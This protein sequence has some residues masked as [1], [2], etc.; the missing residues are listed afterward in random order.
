MIVG[1][2]AGV[3][4]MFHVGHLNLLR[5]AAEQCDR[6]IVGVTTDE[7]CWER[8]GKKP[9]VPYS[10]RLDIVSAIRFVDAAVPQDVYDKFS[11]WETHRF[12]RIFVG[13][14]WQGTGL[15]AEYERRFSAVG[16][17]VLYFPYTEQTSST[18]LREKLAL[19]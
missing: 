7:L 16:A 12:D 15:W 1:Y 2:T 4:D 17:V 13:S 5:R 3:Y 11:A 18:L 8:K 6:L 19:I 14:D 10:E 9:V